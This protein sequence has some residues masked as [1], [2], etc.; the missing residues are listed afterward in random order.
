MT[1]SRCRILELQNTKTAF[2]SFSDPVLL[3][4]ATCFVILSE[5]TPIRNQMTKQTTKKQNNK[6]LNNKKIGFVLTYS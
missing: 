3:I 4:H 6:K 2:L 5:L 1:L